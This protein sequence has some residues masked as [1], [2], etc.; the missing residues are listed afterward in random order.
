MDRLLFFGHLPTKVLQ[1]WWWTGEVQWYDFVLYGP[2]TLHFVM[3]FALGVLIW[4]TR[5]KEYWNFMTTFVMCS[6]MAFITYVLFPAAPPWMADERGL[7]EPI[8]RVSS[9]VWRA[10]GIHDFPG[11]YNKVSPNPVAAVPSLHA[12]YAFLVAF[13]VTRLYKTNWRW[14]AW[15]FPLLIW[16]GTIYQGEHYVIDVIIGILYALVAYFTAPYVVNFLQ[17]KYKRVKIALR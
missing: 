9:E 1:D 10:F 17:R 3:P 5:E 6:F 8:V 15:I 12:A 14:L 16:V 4:R 11:I 2:Y 7:I 13:F